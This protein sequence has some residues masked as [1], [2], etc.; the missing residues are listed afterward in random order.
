MVVVV[1]GWL[2]MM[3]IDHCCSA[4]KVHVVKITGQIKKRLL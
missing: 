3:V 4:D 2:A 1:G